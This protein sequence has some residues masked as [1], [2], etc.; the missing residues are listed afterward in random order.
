VRYRNSQV[1]E[2]LA[3]EYVLGTMSAAVRRRFQRLLN[4]DAGLQA[5][6]REWEQRLQPLADGVP[7]LTPPRSIWIAL[8]ERLGHAAPRRAQK[9]GWLSSLALWRGLSAL[10][11]TAVLVMAVIMLQA[12]EV[13][14]P[15]Y[16]AVMAADESVA[17]IVASARKAPWELT[18]ELIKTPPLAGDRTLHLWAVSAETGKIHP[19]GA[20]GS[21]AKQQRALTEQEWLLIKGAHSLIVTEE[22]QSAALEQPAGPVR[23]KGLCV[24]LG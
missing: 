20:L 1:Q 21:D 16:L 12:P 7:A 8:A 24:Q 13:R 6:V 15:D 9:P 19:L 22:A 5:H 10:A 18:L 4:A 2:R 14:S 17:S 3:R 23:Y 11:S